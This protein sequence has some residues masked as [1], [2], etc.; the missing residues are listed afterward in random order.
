MCFI[1]RAAIKSTHAGS[2]YHRWKRRMSPVPEQKP[3]HTHKE[4][5][6]KMV[7]QHREDWGTMTNRDFNNNNKEKN[8]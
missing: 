6:E 7:G 1:H 2:Y 3:T 5:G 4:E 8:Q